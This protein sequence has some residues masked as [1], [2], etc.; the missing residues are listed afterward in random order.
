MEHIAATPGFAGR[1]WP[2]EMPLDANLS[3]LVA[4]AADFE[5]R[6]GFT[7]SV[8]DGDQIIGCLYI[9]PGRKEGS[10]FDADV[11]SWVIADRAALD[12][13]LWS[14]VSTWLAESWPFSAPEYAPRQR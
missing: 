4:H 12:I 8:L 5:N 11:R 1:D 6:T 9:Y 3:D 14:L 10:G 13:E 7:Y 2:H